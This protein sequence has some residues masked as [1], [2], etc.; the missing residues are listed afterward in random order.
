MLHWVLCHLITRCMHVRSS[1]CCLIP[2][3]RRVCFHGPVREA[4]PFFSSLG[5]QCP[6][7]KDPANFLQEVTTPKGGAL[8]CVDM[9]FSQAAMLLCVCV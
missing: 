5:F 1:T 4:L 2:G 3:C 9:G 7:R 8:L 6:V